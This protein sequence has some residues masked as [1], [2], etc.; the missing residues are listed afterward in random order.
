VGG[1]IHA[2]L[3]PQLTALLNSIFNAQSTH[4]AVSKALA[5]LIQAQIPGGAY[6]QITALQG[7]PG[8]ASWIVYYE[9]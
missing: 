3:D 6:S 1:D 4:A 8:G 9:P 7:A 2:Q 5:A